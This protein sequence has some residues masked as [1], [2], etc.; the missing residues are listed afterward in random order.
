MLDLYLKEQSN[1]PRA[2]HRYQI[3]QKLLRK[4]GGLSVAKKETSMK[5]WL[6]AIRNDMILKRYELSRNA[7][8]QK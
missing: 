5:T 1:M 3:L 2:T 4:P 7:K 6:D 8:V